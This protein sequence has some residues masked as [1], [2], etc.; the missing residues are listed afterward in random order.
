MILQMFSDPKRGDIQCIDMQYQLV[1]V[2]DTTDLFDRDASH[3]T[4]ELFRDIHVISCTQN[5]PENLQNILIGNIITQ[6][7]KNK[8][9]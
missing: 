1:L 9:L 5:V 4:T 7:A 2:Y 6:N 3:L 8:N